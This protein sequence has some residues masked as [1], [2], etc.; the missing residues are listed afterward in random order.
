MKEGAFVVETSIKNCLNV[1]STISS[2]GQPTAEQF[3]L[4]K[5]L[6]YH[7]VINLAMPDSTTAIADEG[8]IV[9]H[10]GMTYI[11]IPVPFDAPS[12][13]HLKQ[14]FDVMTAFS[15]R[16]IWVH[17]A[18]NYRASAFL[19]LYLRVMEQQSV[20]DAQRALLTKWIPNDTW[21]AFMKNSEAKLLAA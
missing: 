11:H 16:K 19:Y 13:E 10:V 20:I 5:D 4:I 2:S 1:T 9:T 21:S 3:Q 18:L 17:C 7:V 12:Q 6:G 15:D 8:N 14:F